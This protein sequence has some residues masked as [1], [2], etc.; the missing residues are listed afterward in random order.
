[1]SHLARALGLL[2]QVLRE[3]VPYQ[4]LQD[5]EEAV[6]RLKNRF[7]NNAAILEA[8]EQALPPSLPLRTNPID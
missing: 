2:R 5:T 6:L 4:M 3:V 8:L 1:M 7:K